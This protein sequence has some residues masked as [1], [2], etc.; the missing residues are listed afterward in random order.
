M[1]NLIPTA[2]LMIPEEIARVASKTILQKDLLEVALRKPTR[3]E[4][5]PHYM[6]TIDSMDV[7]I[8]RKKGGNLAW[9]CTQVRWLR[10]DTATIIDQCEAWLC[11]H[12]HR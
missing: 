5:H 11:W 3:R 2:D 4:G 6:T 1:H 7:V 8:W 12:T 9:V 10:T